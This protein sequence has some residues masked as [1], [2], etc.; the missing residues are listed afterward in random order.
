M[1][2]QNPSAEFGNDRKDSEAFRKVP[3]SSERF[4]NLPNDS[5]AFG[6][7]RNGSERNENHTLSVR[8]VARM[9]ENAG[10]ARTERSI[11]N[12][13]QPNKQGMTRLDS[14]FDTNENKYFITP[15]S[16][17]LAITEEQAKAKK[18][19]DTPPD[20]RKPP[21]SEER[22][23]STFENPENDSGKV[24]SLKQEVMDLAIMNKG[25]DYFIEELRKERER[26]A[27]EREAF[28]QRMIGDSRKIGE[29]ETRLLQLG[30]GSEQPKEAG[31][32]EFDRSPRESEVGND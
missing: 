16:V 19:S 21:Q 23:D 11:V 8:E 1:P 14:Y 31:L 3:Q 4:R 25:K 15:Q 28:I 22:R 2:P 6:N 30:T 18:D 9:F 13:C 27:E 29:L 32:F 24:R 10:V 5:E 17:E 26:F 20:V 12:W 7:L